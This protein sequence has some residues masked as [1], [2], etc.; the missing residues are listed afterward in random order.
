MISRWKG[1]RKGLT[2]PDRLRFIFGIFIGVGTAARPLGEKG[3]VHLGVGSGGQQARTSEISDNSF[4]AW[5]GSTDD[6]QLIEKDSDN[7]SL[8]VIVLSEDSMVS[9][10]R[11]PYDIASYN[12]I[13]LINSIE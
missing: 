7:G 1:K 9:L 8:E 3:I 4:A 11:L 12:G 2:L 10:P 13:E 5:S 6:R